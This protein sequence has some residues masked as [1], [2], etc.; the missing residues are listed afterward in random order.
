MYLIDYHMH[1]KHS[2]DGND[3]ISRLCEN[4]IKKGLDEIAITDHFE[5]SAKNI[6]YREYKPNAYWKDVLAARDKFKGKLNIKMG[7]EL[8][9]PHQFKETSEL[10]LKSLPYDYVIGSAHKF[11][12]GTDVSELNFDKINLDDLYVDYLKELKALAD[13]GQLDCVGHLDLIKRYGANHFKTRITLMNKPELLRDVLKTLIEK[14]RG[15]EINTSGLRQAPKETMPGIDVLKLYRELG[16]EILTIGSDAHF[17]CDVGKG[18]ID[19]VNLAHEAGFN[20]I[21]V[22]ENRRPQWKKIIDKKCSQKISV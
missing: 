14:G 8:G 7:V 12:D 20:Y 4:A 13:W 11:P 22:F 2:T 19:A 5:P 18:V 3:T 16:G 1:S 15:L 6:S 9:Q 10:L 21:T 17:A